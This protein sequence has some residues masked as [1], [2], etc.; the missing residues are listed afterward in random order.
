M[1]KLS[2][3]ELQ[4]IKGGKEIVVST[5]GCITTYDTKTGTYSEDG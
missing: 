2:K 5:E 3:K 4:T 1:K